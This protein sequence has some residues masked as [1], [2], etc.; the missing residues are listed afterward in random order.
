[1]ITLLQWPCCMSPSRNQTP[2]TTRRMVSGLA[3]ERETNSAIPARAENANSNKARS[4]LMAHPPLGL[5]YTLFAARWGRRGTLWV[6]LPTGPEPNGFDIRYPGAGPARPPFHIVVR[7][8]S[9]FAIFLLTRFA[10]PPR[11]SS[12]IRYR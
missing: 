8:G 3:S 10:N 7:T 6:R 1:M 11:L 9:D 5:L 2:G 4:R 12:S